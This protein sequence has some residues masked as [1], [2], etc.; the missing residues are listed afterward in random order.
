MENLRIRDSWLGSFPEKGL[1]MSYENRMYFR[2]AL[3]WVLSGLLTA[4]ATWFAT[5][6]VDWPL[7]LGAIGSTLTDAPLIVAGIGA[8]ITSSIAVWQFYRLWQW[9]RGNADE[10]MVCGCLMGAE[11]QAKWNV[12]CRCMGCRKFFQTR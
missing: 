7:I 12:G 1:T 6:C 10:C 9:Q 3:P 8:I 2:M 5:T 4:L 11:Y